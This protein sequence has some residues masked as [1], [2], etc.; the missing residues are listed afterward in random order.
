[1]TKTII[2]LFIVSFLSISCYAQIVFEKGYYI[3]NSNQKVDCLIKNLDWNNNPKGFEYRMSENEEI[4][5]VS[6]ES[7]NEF[8]VYNVSKFKKF[9]LQIDKS[10]N[11]ISKMSYERNPE[12]TEETALLQVLIEGE[13]SLY[14]FKGQ[15]LEIFF[16]QINDSDID[17]L[18]YKKYL[19]SHRDVHQNNLF[20]QQLWRDLKC[21]SI[22]LKN[23]EEL[24]YTKN[25]LMKFFEKYNKCKHSD[26]TNYEK[27][28]TYKNSE[29]TNHEK[30]SDKDLFSFSVRPGLNI[31]SLDA[32]HFNTDW[33]SIDFGKGAGFRLGVEM[34]YTFP[35]NKNKWAFLFEPSYQL[36]SSETE[37]I[38]YPGTAFERFENVEVNIRSLELAFGIRHNFF[39]NNVSKI[40]I[41][42]S[43]IVDF[44]NNDEYD[45]MNVKKTTSAFAFGV[46]YNYNDKFSTEIRI[47][48]QRSIYNESFWES[49][50]GK[51]SVIFGYTFL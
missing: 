15:G 44:S 2:L 46:G 49:N 14:S 5:K 41:N 3:D 27:S 1:M 23:V 17:Q 7:I 32:H 43:F 29:L 18:I 6:I 19:D 48:T 8:G 25:Q 31:V 39:L 10:S 9:V 45:F 22:S 13:A 35:F 50:Y 16:Y 30:K 51:M 47:Y 33:K 40:F 26:F 42:G 37:Y 11:V 4:K 21:Q 24:I 12:F 20:K 28:N 34:E 38:H 36:Y